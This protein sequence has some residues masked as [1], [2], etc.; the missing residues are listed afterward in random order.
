MSQSTP[1]IEADLVVVGAGAMASAVVVGA[2]EAGAL[3]PARVIAADPD[4]DKRRAMIE[5]GARA[6]PDAGAAFALARPGFAALLAVKPQMLDDATRPVRGVRFDGVAVSVLAG[7]TSARVREALGGAAR[8]VRVMPNTPARVRMGIS[9]VAPGAG[10]LPGDE[11]LALRLFGAVGDVAL[12][13]ESLMDAFTAL[14]G[15]GPAYVF[16]L[17]EAMTAAAVRVGFDEATADRVVR[18]TIRGGAE[19]LSRTPERSAQEL[20]AS[21][22]SKGGTTQAASDVLDDGAVMDAFVR[23][24]VAA[25]DRGAELSKQ[26]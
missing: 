4:E 10:A 6:A 15:S 13:E 26:A 17:A 8:V 9:A 21:V 1:P 2:V 25:R 12:V 20:R 5:M 22:T 23:A 18:A 14:A 3:D 7:A 24:I 11:A 16:Y 19:L